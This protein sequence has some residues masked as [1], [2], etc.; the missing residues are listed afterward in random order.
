MK[1]N[2]IP[3]Q[4]RDE[5][6]RRL[7]RNVANFQL[8]ERTLKELIPT[9]AFGGEIS[10][11]VSAQRQHAK[12]LRKQSLGVLTDELKGR[13]FSA[14]RAVTCDESQEG[15]TFHFAFKIDASAD[16]IKEFKLRWQSL[17]RERN[18]LVHDGLKDYDLTLD[19]DCDRLSQMLDE[20]NTRIHQAIHDL[21]Q[22]D[23]HRVMAIKSMVQHIAE[24]AILPRSG[25]PR[26][27]A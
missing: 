11:L 16:F 18:R 5:A 24:E 17:V 19:E 23:D 20:Q 12:R 27:D 22:L 6:F 10:S 2:P 9:L 8:L 21:R 1:I 7:G 15:P 13:L 4:S 14:D 3:S 25:E 26:D